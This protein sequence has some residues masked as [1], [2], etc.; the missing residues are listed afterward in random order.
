MEAVVYAATGHPQDPEKRRPTLNVLRLAADGSELRLAQTVEL[1]EGAAMP[2][3][4]CVPTDSNTLYVSPDPASFY[5]Y[6]PP[7]AVPPPPHLT[8]PRVGQTVAG[9][10]GVLAYKI[11]PSHGTILPPSAYSETVEPVGS[12]QTDEPA[13]STAIEGQPQDSV[14]GGAGACHICLDAQADVLL[15]ANY[16]SGSVATLP[17]VDSRTGD[18]GPPASSRH[19][20]GAEAG[21]AGSRQAAAH[22]HGIFVDPSNRWVLSC[23]LGT[24]A[25]HCYE[26]GAGRLRSAGAIQLH[27]GAGPRHLAFHPSGAL[28]FTINELDNTVTSLRL[29]A[30][31]GALSEVGH[32]S[33][34]PEGWLATDPPKPFDFCE[35]R[36][37]LSLLM[38]LS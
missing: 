36:N 18:L 7:P 16:E 30:S 9:P 4:Q 21:V 29:D 22:P 5:P 35:C 38:Y 10:L 12:Y 19:G 23:D 25:V 20:A 28:C 15:C 34:L 26:L 32:W 27:A 6:G 1:P 14:P 37:P 11:D 3:F 8:L 24:N 17:V 13:L 2:M 31:S 33:T